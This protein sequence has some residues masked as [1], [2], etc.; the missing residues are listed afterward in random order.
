MSRFYNTQN[1][2]TSKQNTVLSERLKH[3]NYK[4]NHY[5]N[6]SDYF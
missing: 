2:K 1:I 5:S 3:S 6:A 4:L